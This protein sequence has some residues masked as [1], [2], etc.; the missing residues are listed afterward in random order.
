MESCNDANLV[1]NHASRARENDTEGSK[2]ALERCI[3]QLSAEGF[4]ATLDQP[5]CFVYE[6]LLEY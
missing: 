4:T 5:G 2:A 6:Q 1:G 3:D